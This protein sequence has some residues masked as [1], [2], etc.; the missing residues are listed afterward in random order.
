MGSL[1][2]EADRNGPDTFLKGVRRFTGYHS[3]SDQLPSCILNPKHTYI[4]SRLLHMKD[5]PEYRPPHG[6]EPFCKK[7]KFTLK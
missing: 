5:D 4:L 3:Y 6:D 7:K 2:E 1:Y